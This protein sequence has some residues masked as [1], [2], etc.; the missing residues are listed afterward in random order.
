MQIS[1]DNKA[2]FFTSA[3][4]SVCTALKPKIAQ[5]IST[6]YPKEHVQNKC[7]D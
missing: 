3:G 7:R 6:H 1:V 4:C 5:L 2:W